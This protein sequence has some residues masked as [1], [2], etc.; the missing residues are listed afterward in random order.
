M[1]KIF[2]SISILLLVTGC[3]KKDTLIVQVFDYNEE[4]VLTAN[5]FISGL[6][7]NNFKNY[8][9]NEIKIIGIYPKVNAIYKNKVGNLY[10]SFSKNTID[11][12]IISF[13]KYYK[14]ILEKNNFKNDLILLDYNGISLEKVKVFLS[15]EELA[16]ILDKC[17][18]CFYEKI[19][20]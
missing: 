10:Y 1:K 5:I 12:N 9:T 19:S 14:S 4:E 16:K 15:Y 8:F 18:K 6:N 13:K 11:E 17:N 7:T 3:F 2:I 20:P